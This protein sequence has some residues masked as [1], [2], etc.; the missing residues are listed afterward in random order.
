MASLITGQRLSD[1]HNGRVFATADEHIFYHGEPAYARPR[2]T[3]CTGM[4]QL[5]AIKNRA[6]S[7]T[8]LDIKR[9]PQKVLYR[10]YLIRPKHS[11]LES[12]VNKLAH[13][14]NL[15]AMSRKTS[16][17][18]VRPRINLLQRALLFKMHRY[19]KSMQA[20]ISHHIPITILNSLK[21]N[22]A[23]QYLFTNAISRLNRDIK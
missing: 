1:L 7:R 8:M 18:S 19:N 9:L 14:Q 13:Q 4:P 17:I 12:A 11:H 10:G 5:S 22:S 2:R 6:A 20:R 3:K 23:G 16:A 21:R 15:L